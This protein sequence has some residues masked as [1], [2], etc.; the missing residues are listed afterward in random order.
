MFTGQGIG[1][2][3][4]VQRESTGVLEKVPLKSFAEYIQH[5]C[6][7]K[8]PKAEEKTT[9]R[10]NKNFFRAHLRLGIVGVSTSQSKRV[11]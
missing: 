11:W 10:G 1:E 2:R 9:Q 5:M 3:R 4:A 6:V 8:L 7:K